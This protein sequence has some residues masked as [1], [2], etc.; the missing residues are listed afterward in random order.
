MKIV[1]FKSAKVQSGK[2]ATNEAN[3][4]LSL[5]SSYGG[6]KL[7]SRA[8]AELGVEVEDYVV[9]FDGFDPNAPVEQTE[10]YFICAGG[11]LNDNDKP[12]GSIIGKTRGFSYGYIYGSM[13]LQDKTVESVGVDG[14]IKAGKMVETDS[15]SKVATQIINWEL[16]PYNGGELVEVAEG[17]ER[18][19][20]ALVNP[21]IKEHTPRTFGDNDIDNDIDE[22]EIED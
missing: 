3:A 11:F 14:L 22:V 5:S 15:G 10:R 12:E 16:V 2:K 7:N 20:F 13:L 9:M 21:S 18:K 17:V 19:V 4:Q 8:M 1:N 6:F